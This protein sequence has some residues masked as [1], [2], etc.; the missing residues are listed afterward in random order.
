M[1]KIAIL[2]FATATLTTYVSSQAAITKEE[3][4]EKKK[5]RQEKRSARQ[6]KRKEKWREIIRRQRIVNNSAFPVQITIDQ[7]GKACKKQKHWIIKPGKKRNI[8]MLEA[9]SPLKMYVSFPGK[10]NIKIEAA[11]KIAE[12]GLILTT[13]GSPEVPKM[14]KRADNYV[15]WDVTITGKTEPLK[16]VATPK[17][18][19]AKRI[20]RAERRSEGWE[21]GGKVAAIAF[22]TVIV[23]G[24]IAAVVVAPELI[25]LAPLTLTMG[26]LIAL[27]PF[28]LV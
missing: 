10:P 13:S 20:K 5:L 16:V 4:E 1:K 11:G 8:R 2:L 25:L 21:I 23:A 15:Y 12:G 26:P 19:L 17:V 27:A 7:L 22:G 3:R 9:C 6:K 24:T 28:D 18:Y 14:Y